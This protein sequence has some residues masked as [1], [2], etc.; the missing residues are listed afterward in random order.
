MMK[1]IRFF[2]IIFV[3]VFISY[4]DLNF[5]LNGCLIIGFDLLAIFYLSRKNIKPTPRYLIN[6][7][8]FYYLLFV[9]CFYILYF[10]C[11]SFVFKNNNFLTYN[12]L[13]K[14]EIIKALFLYPILEEFIFRK[15]FL[16]NLTNTNT[17]L[18]SIFILSLGFT[19]IHCFTGSALL[20]VFLL[21]TFLSW[22]YLKTG[23]I[24][25]SILLH[26]CNNFLSINSFDLINFLAKFKGK[27]FSIILFILVFLIFFALFKIAN[28]KT[29]KFYNEKE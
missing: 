12:T 15:Y 24:Y 22:I 6:F 5:N 21:S 17:K 20:Y 27:D 13:N 11:I 29:N 18:K 25:L 2:L 7:D 4:I 8:F 23:N 10:L 28:D 1:S 3:F 19:L 26:F 14:Y 16:I 9:I